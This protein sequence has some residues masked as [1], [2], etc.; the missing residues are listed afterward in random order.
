M[1]IN[2]NDCYWADS[3]LQ[4]VEIISD[5]I[6]ITIFNYFLQKKIYIEC[7]QCIGVTEIITWDEIIIESL[8]YTKL[9]NHKHPLIKTAK[10]IHGVIICDPEKN[11]EGIFYEIKITL[12]NNTSF[13][14]VCKEVL[15]H[16]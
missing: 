6:T 7:Y 1:E 5:K 2:Y 10:K 14:V 11:V 4:K 12:I 8:T 16:D 3:Y 15:F 9:P 13:S